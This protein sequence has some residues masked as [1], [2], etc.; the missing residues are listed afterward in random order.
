MNLDKLPL[1]ELADLQE[2]L[3][4]AMGKARTRQITET[5]ARIEAVAAEAGLTVRE[6]LDKRMVQTKGTVKYRNPT[7]P[8]ETWTGRGRKPHWFTRQIES[9]VKLEKMAV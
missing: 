3:S 8:S 9:G 4:T 6:V 7:T 5:R 1:K 2:K